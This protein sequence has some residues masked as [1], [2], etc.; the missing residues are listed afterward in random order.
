MDVNAA[1]LA[2]AFVGG[3]AS[4]LSPCVAPLVPGYMGFLSGAAVCGGDIAVA[5]QGSAAGA[6]SAVACLRPSST[7][8][9]SMQFVAGFS[10]AFIALGMLAGSF[11]TVLAAYRPV[12]ETIAGIVMITMGAFLLRLLPRRWMDTLLRDGRKQLHPVALRS[13]GATGPVALGVVFA[14][15]WSPCIGP[16]LAAI[17]TYAGAAASVGFSVLLLA[18]YSLGF[19]VPFVAIGW[20]WSA[21]IQGLGWVRQHGQVIS[22][23]SGLALILVGLVYLTG[24]VAIFSTWAARLPTSSL[25]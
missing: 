2:I 7:M 25:P 6:A 21:G 3:A 1:G 23:L 18:A 9:T 19:A 15:G 11:G 13:W 14:A 5:P 24:E 20:G 22:L 17:L 16:V 10:L 8:R 4:F 12:M